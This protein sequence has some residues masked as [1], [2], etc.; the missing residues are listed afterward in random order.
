MSASG[1]SDGSLAKPVNHSK[2]PSQQASRTRSASATS[3]ASRRPS[4]SR[5]SLDCSL[6]RLSSRARASPARVTSTGSPGSSRA[7]S[8][9]RR[10][11]VIAPCAS[12]RGSWIR[13]LKKVA[14]G[15]S[16]EPRFAVIFTSP[17]CPWPADCEGSRA[18]QG[19]SHGLP[20]QFSRRL[21]HA[22]HHTPRARPGISRK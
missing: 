7:E 11:R 19:M 18:R 20:P 10:P 14:G 8:R 22:L 15:Q 12:K 3:A 16:S 6:R 5:P 1:E 4:V 2:S 21:E 13:S 17:R 9:T